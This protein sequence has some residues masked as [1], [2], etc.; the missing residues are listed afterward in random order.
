[1]ADGRFV[2]DVIKAPL[3]SALLLLLPEL[4]V[5]QTGLFNN[6]V[7]ELG[8]DSYAEKPIYDVMPGNLLVNLGYLAVGIYW[9][10]YYGALAPKAL[11]LRTVLSGSVFAWLSVVYTF[12]QSYRILY[13]SQASA[14]LDQWITLTI[15]CHV[16]TWAAGVEDV[17]CY[18]LLCYTASF[19]SYFL[20]LL[21][22]VGFELALGLHVVIVI[23][24]AVRRQGKYGDSDSRAVFIKALLCCV[25][26][27]VLK[28]LDLPLADYWSPNVLSGHFLSK[29]CDV[30]QMYYVVKLVNS[31]DLNK[32]KA[33]KVE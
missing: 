23:L 2:Q 6:V 17:E 29:L 20:T 24:L 22:D 16:M 10:R 33:E 30:G 28:V 4:I 18:N 7:T 11:S 12:I 25:G 13:Q 14:V 26:F 5:I 9:L 27:V 15:F 21:L 32:I 8:Y 3:L 1:M 31:W 19:L